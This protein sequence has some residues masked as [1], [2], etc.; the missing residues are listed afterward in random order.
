MA[1]ALVGRVIEAD[2][3]FIDARHASFPA[4]RSRDGD[5]LQRAGIG[6]ERGDIVGESETETERE[7]E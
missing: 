1:A 5:E 2:T 6:P 7:A 3:G 4:T